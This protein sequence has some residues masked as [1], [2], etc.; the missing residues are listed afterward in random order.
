MADDVAAVT[1]SRV[2]ILDAQQVFTIPRPR[3]QSVAYRTKE[4]LIA[5]SK[6][7]AVVFAYATESGTRE[8][9]GFFDAPMFSWKGYDRAALTHQLYDGFRSALTARAA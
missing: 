3:L 6:R 9:A 2:L 5:G 8:L 7:E 1:E 4:P